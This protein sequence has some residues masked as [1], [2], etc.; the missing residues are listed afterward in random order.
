M[1]EEE[2]FSVT[3]P[4]ILILQAYILACLHPATF[5]TG[6]IHTGSELQIITLVVK[7]MLLLVEE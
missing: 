2:I 3:Q 7:H 4:S 5:M 1:I 6:P